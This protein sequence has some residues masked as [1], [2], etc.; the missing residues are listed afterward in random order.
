MADSSLLTEATRNTRSFLR[1]VKA[2]FD[3]STG[4]DHDGTNSKT[5]SASVTY[6]VV[7][8]MAAAGTAAANAA[9]TTS[10]AARIDHVHLLGTHDHSSAT[11]G[12]ATLGDHAAGAITLSETTVPAGTAVYVARDND[13]DLWANA[14]TGKSIVLAVAGVSEYT[15]SATALA[16]A[17][18]NLTLS[19]GYMQFSGAGYIDLGASAYVKFGTNP[20]SAGVLRVPNNTY[21]VT[22]R[23]AGN[24][25]DVSLIKADAS[26]LVAFGANL[27]AHTV[28]GAL[29]VSTGGAAIT[30]NSTVTGNLTISGTMSCGAFTFTGQVTAGAGL[31]MN[32]TEIVLDVDGDSS[33]TADTDDQLDLRLNGTDEYV[34]TA[35]ALDINA[36]SLILDADADTSVT[37]DTDNRIDVALGGVDE[38]RYSTG[39][40]AFQVATVISSAA[41]N[42]DLTAAAASTITATVGAV[43]A[44][45]STSIALEPT[46]DVTIKNGTGLIVGNTAQVT[47]TAANELQVL[48][49]AAADSS[50]T[51]GQWAAAATGPAIHLVK[52]RN[53]AIGSLTIVTAGDTLGSIV[54][55]GDDGSDFATPAASI[56]FASDDLNPNG[57]GASAPGA[58]DMPGR[59][60]FSTTADGANTV[61]EVMRIDRQQN[62]CIGDGNGLVIGSTTFRALANNTSELQVLGTG[63]ADA[64]IL[65]GQW[66]AAN[67]GPEFQFVKSHNGTIGSNTIVVDDEILGS[68]QWHADDGTDFTTIAASIHA[69]VHGTPGVNDMPAALIFGVTAD[70]AGGPTNITTERMR[71][72]P[73]GQVTIGMT[74]DTDN[75]GMTIGLTI[76]QGAADNEIIALKSSDVAHAY[77]TGAETDTYASVKKT[78]AAEGGLTILSL[79]ENAATTNV[80]RIGSYGGQADTTKSTAGRALVEIYVTQHDGANALADVGAD[81]NIFAVLCRNG[82]GD[83]ARMILDEDGDA[84][85]AGTVTTVGAGVIGGTLT[86]GG[87]IYGGTGAN[88]DLILASTTHATEG[89]VSIPDGTAGLI[90]GGVEAAAWAA[91]DNYIFLLNSTVAPAGACGGGAATGAGLY[92][93][94]GELYTI[95]GAGNSTLQTPHNKAGKWMSNSYRAKEDQT[96]RIYIQEFIEEMIKRD[97]S[98]KKFIEVVA[99]NRVHQHP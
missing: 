63:T 74:D 45:A 7:G 3:T 6:G 44:V 99:G 43:T 47:T 83:L 12:G 38:L 24:D 89:C 11:T 91:A 25:G 10:K 77:T 15:F 31:D 66:A 57:A 60:V 18:N 73:T 53:A 82:G 78:T 1:Q 65:I 35:A 90:L 72:G 23:N 4:H 39:A 5:L 20:G 87:T 62:V 55:Y 97:P 92:A 64:G 79:S 49:T 58:N 93:A 86:I 40:F 42:L 27:A 50:M 28:A 80:T 95:D 37:A 41:G 21:A 8:E 59:I 17:A 51:L 19:T 68:I 76:D 61:T 94:A 34:F 54:A 9:G 36:N 33:L 46:T 14:L 30:G 29:T 96:I 52:S 98:L 88:G 26:D 75:A 22:S 69:K 67:T 84:W 13:G 85:L 70:A 32:G 81:G 2:A 16:L 48:G 56:V 71:I